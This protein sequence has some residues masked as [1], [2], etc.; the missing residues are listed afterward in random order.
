MNKVQINDLKKNLAYW[1][2]KAAQGEEVHITKFNKPFV[3]IIPDQ[4]DGRGLHWGEF[5]GKEFVTSPLKRKSP[6]TT[7]KLLEMIKEDRD[8][9]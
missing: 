4:E 6:L 3:K 5:V 8:S 7:E 1:T 2:E 9:D